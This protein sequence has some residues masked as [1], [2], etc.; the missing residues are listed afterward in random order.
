MHS[1]REFKTADPIIP[2]AGKKRKKRIPDE[3]MR[4]ADINDL[5]ITE[6]K[7]VEACRRKNDQEER[8][9][10]K[11]KGRKRSAAGMLGT[12]SVGKSTSEG[13]GN[14]CVDLGEQI[15]KYLR[16]NC[17]RA[18]LGSRSPSLS[19]QLMNNQ[20]SLDSSTKFSEFFQVISLL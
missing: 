17:G 2:Q 3:G 13:H 16:N 12:E 8:K 1:E 5:I 4:T 7:K 9:G 10:K 11:W 15:S 19:H 18:T 14:M 6:R 20:I